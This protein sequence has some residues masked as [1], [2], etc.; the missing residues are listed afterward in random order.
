M[1]HLSIDETALHVVAGA[2]WADHAIVPYC[3]WSYD[4]ETRHLTITGSGVNALKRVVWRRNPPSE[5]RLR[6]ALP[7]LA[8]SLMEKARTLER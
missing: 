2:W 3:V 5:K 6:I 4:L 8:R 1:R 7:F